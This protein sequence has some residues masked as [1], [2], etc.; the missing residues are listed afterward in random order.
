MEPKKTACP[1]VYADGR[2]CSGHVYRAAAYGPTQ[3][4][5]VDL[6]DVRKFRLWC[7]EKDDHAGAV[8]NTE[9]KLRM[10]FYPDE[11]PGG[12]YHDVIAMC[13][14]LRS[15]EPALH[16]SSDGRNPEQREAEEINRRVMRL[17]PNEWEATRHLSGTAARKRRKALRTRIMSIDQ[18]NAL[19]RRYE[20][21]GLGDQRN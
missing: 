21:Q 3:Q 1:F 14:N 13:E 2:N 8:S 19:N 12:I 16:P 7:S 20:A 6:G 15:A 5:Y 10:E 11:I 17:W 9:S 18:K 4:G